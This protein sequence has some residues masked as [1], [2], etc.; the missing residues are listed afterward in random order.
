MARIFFT[1]R[2]PGEASFE[3][4]EPRVSHVRFPLPR[5]EPWHKKKTIDMNSNSNTNTDIII[6]I[7]DKIN[8]H[9]DI[10]IRVNDNIQILIGY[11]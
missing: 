7:G 10:T 11:D 1:E 6:N 8:I 2:A 4:D 5:A 9:I 3:G